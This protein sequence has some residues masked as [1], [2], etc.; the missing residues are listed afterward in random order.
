MIITGHVKTLIFAKK[1]DSTG[2][3]KMERREELETKGI[4]QLMAERFAKGVPRGA[5]CKSVFDDIEITD[6]NRS[7]VGRDELGA[8]AE[9]YKLSPEITRQI[10]ELA[11]PA[12]KTEW[13]QPMTKDELYNDLN[14]DGVLDYLAGRAT[15]TLAP[16]KMDK[17]GIIHI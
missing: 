15:S 4:S 8:F 3:N 1:R 13:K 9:K 2:G 6:K 14:D 12:P 7:A 16:S 10:M 5:F 17:N 11:F